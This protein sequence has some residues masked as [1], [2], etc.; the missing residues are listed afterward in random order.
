MEVVGFVQIYNFISIAGNFLM[1]NDM[2]TSGNYTSQIKSLF[3]LYFS[4]IILAFTPP[5]ERLIPFFPSFNFI[6]LEFML[7]WWGIALISAVGMTIA[8]QYYRGS[9]DFLPN[10][11]PG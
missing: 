11:T 9:P 8:L 5:N 1:T 6:G 3:N 2:S 10:P 7:I 4:G